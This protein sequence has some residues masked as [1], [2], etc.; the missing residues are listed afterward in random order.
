MR[1]A[2]IEPSALSTSTPWRKGPHRSSQELSSWPISEVTTTTTDNLDIR[3]VHV[4]LLQPLEVTT[5]RFSKL[6]KTHQSMHT[7]EDSSSTADIPMPT[8]KQ[9][10]CP[11]K[12]LTRL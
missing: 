5:Q 6:K 11:H 12:I 3:N 4:A 10:L 1:S 9:P 8:D 7:A 2:G